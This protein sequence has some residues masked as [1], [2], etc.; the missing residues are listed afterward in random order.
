MRSPRVTPIGHSS[1][2]TTGAR[3]PR[4]RG[5]PRR[6]HSP[7]LFEGSREVVI[8]HQGQ[9]YRLRVTRADKLI[10]TK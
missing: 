1:P 2:Q 3:E 7:T 5:A 8:V 10:L 4:D 6:I 9:E